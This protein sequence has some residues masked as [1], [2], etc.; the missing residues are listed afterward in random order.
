MVRH[1]PHVIWDVVDGVTV[2]CDTETGEIFEMNSTAG[3]IWTLCGDQHGVDGIAEQVRAA[4]PHE[5]LGK[6]RRDVAEVLQLL[7]SHGI[8]QDR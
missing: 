7:M 1:S 2:V 5:E 3:L 4:Y 8:V 6:I